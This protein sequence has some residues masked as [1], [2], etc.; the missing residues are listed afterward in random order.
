[1]KEFISK[2]TA[3]ENLSS[4]EMTRAMEIIVG[5][6]AQDDEIEQFLL[7]LRDKGETVEEIVAAARVMRSRAVKLGRNFPEL[8][9]TCG[10]GGDSK[11]TINVSTLV[12]IIAA[13]VGVKVAKHGNRSVSSVCGSADILEMLGVRIDL[14]PEQVVESLNERNFAFLFAPKFH[15]AMK[16]AMPARQRIKG[17][18]LFNLLGPLSNPAGVSNQLLGVYDERLVSVM[19]RVL[20]ELGMH[21]ALVVY[22]MDGLDEITLTG[23][24][25]IGELNSGSIQM[26]DL[27]P[28][29]MELERRPLSEIQC[30]SK[31]ECLAAAVHVLRNQKSGAMK[32]VV[33]LNAGAA[34]YIAGKA[35]TI[36]RGI[37]V[38]KAAIEQGTVSRWLDD[39][40]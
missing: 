21:R 26:Y 36:K 30:R 6:S 25:K 3:K 28:E 24:T 35:E 18:T 5:G 13:S 1:M 12:A 11:G 8:L 7:A 40:K 2:L 32:D 20:K 33:C 31:E 15:P 34:L 4:A 37:E 14:T 38:A 10:T 22:G 27:S 16:N 29:S 9:D 17:K 19:V 39:L 23:P